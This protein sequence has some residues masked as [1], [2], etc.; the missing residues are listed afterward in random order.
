MEGPRT[1]NRPGLFIGGKTGG[2]TAGL[3]LSGRVMRDCHARGR[4][5]WLLKYLIY[6]AKL[7]MYLHGQVAGQIVWRQL[8]LKGD[9]FYLYDKPPKPPAMP[10]RWLLIYGDRVCAAAGG[11][12][13]G[14]PAPSRGAGESGRRRR[15][16]Q[17]RRELSGRDRL[18]DPGVPLSGT[19]GA[20]RN[21]IRH[22]RA[23]LRRKTTV[24]CRCF[25]ALFACCDAGTHFVHLSFR[26]KDAFR[27]AS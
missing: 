21:G 6:S 9:D 22:P 12:G 7:V 16:R 27:V 23:T 1:G 26:V 2:G 17:A 15:T 10:C 8:S 13:S 18:R 20:V 24:F 19:P 3:K 5:G 14:Q 25:D 11:F 4:D